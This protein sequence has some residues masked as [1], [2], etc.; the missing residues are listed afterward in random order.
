MGGRR[1]DKIVEIEEFLSDL[2]EFL[3]LSFDR[4]MLDKKSRA[5]CERF[6]E[7]IVEGVI[8]LVFIVVKEKGLRSP[9][10]NGD[11][12]DVLSENS[13]ISSELSDK[14]TNAKSMRN[15]LAHRY[16]R[17]NDRLVFDSLKEELINDV[18]EFLEAVR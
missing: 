11:A 4:Y 3:P 16:G 17:V 8:D 12:L 18:E 5:A 6:C 14:L 10:S 1:G 13:V 15:W 2:K 9:S 7:K